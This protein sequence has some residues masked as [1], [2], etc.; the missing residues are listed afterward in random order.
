MQK[1]ASE[2]PAFNFLVLYV[3][4]AHPGNNIACHQNYEDKVAAAREAAQF[5]NDRRTTLVDTVDGEAHR[6]YGAL[7]NS[8]YVISTDGIVQYVNPWN[9]T[10]YLRPILDNILKEQP[11]E[12]LKFRP[13]TPGLVQSFKTLFKGG[14]VSFW[15]F[16]KQSP[17]LLWKHWKAGNL[18]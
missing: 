15:D 12:H 11:T 1:I 5:Y 13:A 3:R 4:E 16:V 2:Y 17:M 10:D 9:N 8:I 14:W 7:P 6:V 18:F